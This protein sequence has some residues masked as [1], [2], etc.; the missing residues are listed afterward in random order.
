MPPIGHGLDWIWVIIYVI[1][2]DWIGLGHKVNG[3]DWVGFRKLDPCPTLDHGYSRQ[4]SVA[5]PYIVCSTI[6]YHSSS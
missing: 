6:G 5:T 3:L 1:I 4:R 2:V